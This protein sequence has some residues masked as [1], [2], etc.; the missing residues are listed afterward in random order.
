MNPVFALFSAVIAMVIGAGL[1]QTAESVRVRLVVSVPAGTTGPVYIAGNIDRLGPWKP[2]A[3]RLEPGADGTFTV[4]FDAPAGTELKFK[5]TRGA[6][7]S[8]EKSDGGFEIADR[9]LAVV[10]GLPVQKLTVA[11]FADGAAPPTTRASTVTGTLRLHENVKSAFLPDSRTIRVWLPPGYDANA[12]QRYPVIYFHDGQNLFDNATS[13]FGVEWGLDEA[14]TR[15]IESK[16]ARPAIIVGIDNTPA[17]TMELTPTAVTGPNNTRYGGNGANY[18]KF[19]VTELKPFIDRTYRTLP[20]RA[21]TTVG[22]SSLG[23]LISLYLI[24]QHPDIFST[25]AVV[26]PALWWDNESLTNRVADPATFPLPPG[27]RIYLDM[28]TA[29]GTSNLIGTQAPRSLVNAQRLRD[30]LRQRGLVEGKTFLYVEDKD[31]QHNEAAWAQRAPAMLE[32]LLGPDS[33]K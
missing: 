1:A 17:R 19:L 24:G 31:A 12:E 11:R 13:A 3:L 2:D 33:K 16:S 5:F 20:D 7:T 8:V 4:E 27:T 18:G 22:G 28:G 21:N 6:W 25:A 10:A 30:I 32:F 23:G 9:T 14:L 26:S 15:L 29:E